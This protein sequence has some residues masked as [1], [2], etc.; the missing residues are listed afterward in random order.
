MLTTAAVAQKLGISV[1]RVQVLI[2][3]GLLLATKHGQDWL[4]TEQ[5]LAPCPSARLAGHEGGSARLRMSQ[6]NTHGRPTFHYCAFLRGCLLG[7]SILLGLWVLGAVAVWLLWR[8][9]FSS[10]W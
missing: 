8:F 7:T 4:M 5:A 3:A 6:P 10:W 2:Q 9:M 1:K